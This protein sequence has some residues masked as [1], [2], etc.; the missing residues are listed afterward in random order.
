MIVDDD[1]TTTN[2]LQTLLELDGYDVVVVARGMDVIPT[3]ETTQPDLIL[4]DYHLNDMHGVEV[5]KAIRN[6][7]H[8]ASMPVIIAS[9]MD[10]SDEALAEGANDFLMKPF[11]PDDLPAL[12]ERYIGA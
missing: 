7:P 10:K 9:G 4:M 11:E 2:L 5:L 6:H 8:M 1:S 3:A 12:F